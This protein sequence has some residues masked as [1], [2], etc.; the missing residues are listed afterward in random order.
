VGVFFTHLNATHTGILTS[1]R[2]N[3]PHDPPSLP[4]ERSPTI[5][6]VYSKIHSFGG[7]LEPR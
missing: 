7:G 2:S 3:R 1:L 5:L 4:R 6:E